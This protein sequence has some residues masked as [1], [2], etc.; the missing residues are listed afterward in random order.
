MPKIVTPNSGS[1]VQIT[2]GSNYYRFAGI[3]FFALPGIYIQDAIQ[4]GIGIEPSA[5]QLPHDIDFDRDYIHTDAGA[6]GKRGIALNGG[7]TT[8][9]AS[10]TQ[11]T[12]P[13]SFRAVLR[14]RA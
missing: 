13:L 11:R 1:A 6:G 2:T 4:V 3:E 14:P 8:V 12:T 9:T 10:F 7:N 5:D